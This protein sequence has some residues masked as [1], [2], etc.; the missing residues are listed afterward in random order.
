MEAAARSSG[1]S[2][3]SLTCPGLLRTLQVS[4]LTLLVINQPSVPGKQ[5]WSGTLLYSAQGR[6][7]CCLPLHL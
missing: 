7:T 3:L 6:L 1:F 5:G 4:A 2:L